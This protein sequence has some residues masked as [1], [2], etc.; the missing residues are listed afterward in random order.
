LTNRGKPLKARA[1]N[2]MRVNK[3]HKKAA[4]FLESNIKT[5][6]LPCHLEQQCSAHSR[7]A[8][9]RA[10]AKAGGVRLKAKYGDLGTHGNYSRREC[11]GGNA[12]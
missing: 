11:D 6:L 12:S 7:D 4:K 10:N 5:K 2:G 1:E 3:G 9:S 8:S